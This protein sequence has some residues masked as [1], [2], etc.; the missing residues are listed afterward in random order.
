[1]LNA[2]IMASGFSSRMGT[3]KLLL[4]Y[5]GKLLIEHILDKVIACN[6][7][8]VTLVAQNEEII[9]IGK[10]RKVN[11]IHNTRAAEGQSASIKLGIN[12][13]PDCKGYAFFTADQPLLDVE[14]IELLIDS[15]YKTGNSII[16][17]CFSGKRGTPVIFPEKFKSELLALSGDTGGKNVIEKHPNEVRFIEVHKESTLWDIDTEE[18]Y[19]K[20]IHM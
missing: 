11:V 8:S 14:T 9:N 18:D 7:A 10:K 17:P 6:F 3:N 1:M 12:N 15:F 16:V 13:S 20:L 19:R 2:I 4:P 5:K